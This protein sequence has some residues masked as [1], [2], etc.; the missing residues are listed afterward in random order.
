MRSIALMMGG[1]P[2]RKLACLV[3]LQVSASTVLRI[4]RQIPLPAHHTP[5]AVG[6]DEVNLT[7]GVIDPRAFKK[8]GGS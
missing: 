7:L 3:G 2:G 1:N 6:V 4:L 5:K 8:A